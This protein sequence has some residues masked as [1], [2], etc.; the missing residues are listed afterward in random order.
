MTAAE[1]ERRLAS[2][3]LPGT[4]EARGRLALLTVRG[5][6]AWRAAADHDVRAAA[7]AHAGELGFANLAIE[8]PDDAEDSAPLSRP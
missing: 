8:L 3:G 2:L 4:V 1:L 7:V 5:A 6:D